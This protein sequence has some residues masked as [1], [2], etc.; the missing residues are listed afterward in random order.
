M[1]RSADTSS[2]AGDRG[3]AASGRHHRVHGPRNH[4]FPGWTPRRRAA[5]LA[6]RGLNGG[7]GDARSRRLEA[8]RR[9]A[10]PAPRLLAMDADGSET[11]VRCSL[12][13]A[14]AGQPDLA[15]A[16]VLLADQLATT[17]AAIHAVPR[18][19]TSVAER[20]RR[21]TARR[22]RRIGTTFASVHWIG[23]RPR[24]ARSRS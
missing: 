17:Q 22:L 23:R 24:L 18:P 13:S 8:V 11:G 1:G 3:G 19:D 14:L 9:H 15:P 6:R 2:R 20:W 4:C 16:D 5:S 12:T 21:R 7:F 10:I